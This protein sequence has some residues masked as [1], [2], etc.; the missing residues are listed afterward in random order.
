MYRV[1]YGDH[2]HTKVEMLS[3]WNIACE[4]LRTCKDHGL[5]ILALVKEPE[6]VEKLDHV[7]ERRRYEWKKKQLEGYVAK[8][9]YDLPPDYQAHLDKPI[10]LMDKAQI[11]MHKQFPPF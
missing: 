7:N 3:T 2:L 6:T 11:E 10:S 8:S 4:F 9:P 1:T 5:T